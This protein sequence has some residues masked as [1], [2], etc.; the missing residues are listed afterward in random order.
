MDFREG[1]LARVFWKTL[2]PTSKIEDVGVE[3]NS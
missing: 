1:G 3:S 2:R